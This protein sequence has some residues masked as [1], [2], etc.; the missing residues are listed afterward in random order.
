MFEVSD[1]YRC[2]EAG[3]LKRDGT[4]LRFVLFCDNAYSNLCLMATSFKGG[5]SNNPNQVAE[6]NCVHH[7]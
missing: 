2:L 5:I 4:R 7:C 1:R 3:L 6:V